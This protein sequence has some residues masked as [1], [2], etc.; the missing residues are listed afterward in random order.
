MLH[1]LKLSL[2][3]CTAL[4][5]ATL[6]LPHVVK[7]QDDYPK[8]PITLVVAFSPGG[9]SDNLARA[10]YSS[11]SDVLGQPVV[12]ENRPGAGGFVAWRSIEGAKPDGYTVLLAENALAINPALRPAE[13]FDPRKAFEAIGRVGLSGMGV[14]VNPKE[15]PVTSLAELIKYSQ[16]NEINFSSSGVGSV[17]HMTFEAMADVTG[18]RAEHVPYRG[19]GESTAALVGGHVQAMHTG[20]GHIVRMTR[21]N[22]MRPLA[23]ST[24]ERYKALPDVPTLSELG[25]K[26]DVELRF[27]WGMFVPTGTPA[28][29]KQKLQDALE[30]ILQDPKVAQRMAGIEVEPAF[31]P[32]E[33][34]AK[35][36]DSEMTNWRAFAEKKGVKLE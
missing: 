14:V 22:D 3:A 26:T 9:S 7:A 20:L 35:L 25:Y 30:K 31:A 15:V 16:E 10:I 12:V 28:P 23:V 24:A 13:P 6:A 1:K 27:W 33:D 4:G 29:V 21:E 19:G 2:A 18:I 11:L 36:L 17:S 8:Q 34:M 32:G 5:M